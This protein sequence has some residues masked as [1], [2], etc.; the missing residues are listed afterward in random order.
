MLTPYLGLSRI[1]G[2]AGS[3]AIRLPDGAQ[4]FDDEALRWLTRWEQEPR[5]RDLL[6]SIAQQR[7]SEL[8]EQLIREVTSLHDQSDLDEEL[9]QLP[10]TR[11]I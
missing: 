4:E 6:E 10:P 7:A 11:W 8:V 5:N 2:A 1:R 3:G 9:D